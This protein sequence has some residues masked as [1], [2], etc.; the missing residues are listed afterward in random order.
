MND[1]EVIQLFLSDK[2][3]PDD[4]PVNM[5]GVPTKYHDFTNIFSKTYTCTLTPH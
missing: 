5:T 1:T 2:S 4:T 3:T